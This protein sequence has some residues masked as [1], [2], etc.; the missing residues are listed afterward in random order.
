MSGNKAFTNTDNSRIESEDIHKSLGITIYSKLTFKTH[1]N[2]LLRNVV[3]WSVNLKNLTANAARFLKCVWPF[4]DIAK[5]VKRVRAI[6][7]QH[8]IGLI[9]MENM[10]VAHKGKPYK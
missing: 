8:Q 10:A 5:A 1:I 4:Y 2:P 6:N 3:K 9:N 7:D